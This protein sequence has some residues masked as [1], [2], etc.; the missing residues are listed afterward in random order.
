ML[1][2]GSQVTASQRQTFIVFYHFSPFFVYAIIQ[3]FGNFLSPKISGVEAKKNADAR[4]VKWA[5]ALT[6]L[7]SGTAYL[8]TLLLCLFSNNPEFTL[9]EIF[10]PN[11]SFPPKPR[12][13]DALIKAGSGLFMRLDYWI[14]VISVVIYVAKTAEMMWMGGPVKTRSLQKMRGSVI[15]ASAGAFLATL[16]L[17]PGTVGSAVLYMRESRLREWREE[18]EKGIAVSEKS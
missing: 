6:G 16:V 10:V 14:V 18:E 13:N 12:T 11:F 15:I 1:F 3:S 17:G 7:W 5:Y 2:P 9:G 8:T 4:M